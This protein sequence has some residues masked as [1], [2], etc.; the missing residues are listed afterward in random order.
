MGVMISIE[1]GTKI[2]G[3][4]RVLEGRE[5]WETMAKFWKEDIEKSKT[6]VTWNSDT[7]RR[8]LLLNVVLRYTGEENSRNI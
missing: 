4:H 8:I 1:S 6:R 7:N 2:E 3:A 5:V